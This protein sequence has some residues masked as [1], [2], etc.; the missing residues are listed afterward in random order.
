[1]GKRNIGR[2]AVNVLKSAYKDGRELAGIWQVRQFISDELGIKL[3]KITM[4]QAGGWDRTARLEISDQGYAVTSPSRRNA[5][6]RN[7]NADTKER[8]DAHRSP[9][10]YAA[11]LVGNEER[12]AK[13]NAA[14]A[15]AS[16]I[17]IVRAAQLAIVAPMLST[18]VADA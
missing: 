5:Y 9:I 18:L 3:T 1:M 13:A 15:D 4:G 7:P 6:K 8:V 10:K 14:Q 2:E 12:I 11:T 16:R 17:E